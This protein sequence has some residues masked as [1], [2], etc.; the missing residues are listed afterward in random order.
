MDRHCANA[1]KIAEFLEPH[2][3]VQSVIYP[4]LASHAQHSLA[5]KQMSGFGGMISLRLNG[6]FEACKRLLKSVK[7]FTVAESLG[8]V[9]SL[10]EH[11]SSMTH[12][13]VPRVER[14]RIGI[15]DSLIRLSVGLE[16]VEDLITD[17]SEGLEQV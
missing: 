1:Q 12:A 16:D 11:P 14:E 2:P 10:I 13:S 5:E 7:V 15:T 3:K 6:N 4:G 9:E 8:G 17:L